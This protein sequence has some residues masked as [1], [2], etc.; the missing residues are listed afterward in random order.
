MLRSINEATKPAADASS[1]QAAAGACDPVTLEILRGA[2]RAVQAEMEALIERTA[3]SAFIREKK[4]FYTSLFDADGVM[5][6]G[7]NMPVFGDMSGSVFKRFPPETMR[8]GDLYWYSD[9]YESTGAVSH[10]NDQVLIAPVFHQGRRCAFVMSWAHFA[11]IGGMRAGSI[12]PDATDIF[13]EGI[14]VPATKLIEAGRV[15]EAVL[16]LFHRNSRFPEQSRGDM[17]AL[18]ASVELGV[19]RV[20]EILTR[21][22]APVVED[23]LRQLLTRT[24]RLVR[25]RLA[26]TFPYGTHRFT[27]AIDSDGHGNGPY[28]IRFAL[29]RERGG[30]GEDR[31]I[32]DASETD[33]QSPGPVNFLM[34]PGVP[35]MA[36]GLYYLGGDPGQVCNAGGPQALDE[37]ILRQGSLLAPRFPAPLGMRGLTMMRVLAGLMGLVNVAGGKAPAA[38]SAYVI[39]LMR[40]TFTDEKNE[41]QPF[42]LS[43]GIGV[44]YGARPYADGIDAVYFVAQENYPVEFVELGYPVRLTHYGIASDSGGPGRHRGGCGIVREYEILAD[45]AVLAVRI[46][47]VLNPPGGIA[48]GMSGGAGRAVINPGTERERVLR[49]LSD[50]NR[51]TRG[52]ILR[53]VTGGG[54]GH[55]HPFDRPAEEV[56]EDVLGGFV[57]TEAAAK[58]YG[59]VIAAEEVDAAATAAL[60]RKRPPAR[61]FH[62][63]EY[64]DVLA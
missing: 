5:A 34:N 45:E 23:G 60:R 18:M 24:R 30:K 59:V 33:D 55:G 47:G 11:D 8:P 13:Q 38:H 35:G 19:K 50:G 7:S 6:V 41:K 29:T 36:L 52:D 26:E 40:G 51:V 37:V 58:H 46:D 49:P 43:D 44:G 27:D 9:C 12:S 1:K 32:F 42:L 4:D 17:R 10:S 15:N 21:F 63:N 39:T 28:R 54:G 56:L 31:F 61:A 53:I 20:E 3:I 2:I 62:R 48:G 64:V 16:E 25:E 57:S 22:G 14:I